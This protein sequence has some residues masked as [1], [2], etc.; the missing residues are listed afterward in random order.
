MS[1]DVVRGFVVFVFESQPF[2]SEKRALFFSKKL[3]PAC[4]F[5]GTK[6]Y[7]EVTN[8]PNKQSLLCLIFLIQA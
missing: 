1:Y 5:N 7:R 8:Q 4:Q 3:M 6:T 2:F